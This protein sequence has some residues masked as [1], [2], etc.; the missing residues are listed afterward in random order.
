[1][2]YGRW[3]WCSVYL[4]RC[5]EAVPCGRFT[6]VQKLR[7]PRRLSRSNHRWYVP[8]LKSCEFVTI[9]IHLSAAGKGFE[10]MECTVHRVGLITVVD[11]KIKLLFSSTT[12]HFRVSLALAG[13]LRSLRLPLRNFV[14]RFLFGNDCPIQTSCLCRELPCLRDPQRHCIISE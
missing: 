14:G 7:L 2:T 11:R 1:M 9:A 5:I 8:S 4:T 13:T 10:S 6:I 12:A 3:S